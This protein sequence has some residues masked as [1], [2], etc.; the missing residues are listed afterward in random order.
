MIELGGDRSLIMKLVTSE[1]EVV[2][3]IDEWSNTKDEEFKSLF[4]HHAKYLKD[5]SDPKSN[6]NK[7]YNICTRTRVCRS[8][9][10]CKWNRYNTK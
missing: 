3:A 10:K 1:T 8:N 2:G 4:L 7:R 9:T 5:L 6:F